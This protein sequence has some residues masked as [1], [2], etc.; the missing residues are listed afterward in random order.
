MRIRFKSTYLIGISIAI[1]IIIADFLLFFSFKEP[2]GPTVRWFY[3]IL[4]VAFSIGWAQFWYDYLMELKR[5]KRLEEKFLDFVRNMGSAVKSG[6]SI[7]SAIL[8]AAAKDYGELNPYLNKLA[9]QI[10]LGIPIHQAL[11]TFAKDTTNTTIQRAIAI[12]IEAEASGGDIQQVLESVTSSLVSVRKL[13]EERKSSTYSQ[14]VNGYIVYFVFIAIM[15]VMQLY[16]FPKLSAMA[17]S[18]AG[19]MGAGI[20]LLGGTSSG[21]TAKVNLDK[22]FFALIMIQG[23]FAGIMIGKFSEGSVKKGLVH[24]LILVTLGALIVTTAKG[25]I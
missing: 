18:N 8:Q 2:V 1:I 4:I 19:G 17:G 11:V 13:Q 3:P 9:N 22:I 7:P 10:R 21:S 14:I 23:F 15:L 16:L 24:S 25:G 20:S 6:I 5:M 12:V